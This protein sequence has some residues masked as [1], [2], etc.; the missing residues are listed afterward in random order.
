MPF[1]HRNLHNIL[2]QIYTRSQSRH[3]FKF[4]D[5]LPGRQLMIHQIDH[6]HLRSGLWKF[7]IL[8]LNRLHMERMEHP[9]LDFFI[10]DLFRTLFG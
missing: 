10:P 3:L 2:L 5:P 1:K 4:L 9:A 6:T 7:Q 8:D